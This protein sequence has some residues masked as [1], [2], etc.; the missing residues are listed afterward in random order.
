MSADVFGRRHWRT[1]DRNLRNGILFISTH[2]NPWGGCEELW[3][4]TA[5]FLARQGVAV[6]ASVQG[7]VQ[8]D[9]R[10]SALAAVGVD[11]RPRPVKPSLVT[12]GRR[13]LSGRSTMS[14]DIADS[15][16]GASPRLVVISDG[17]VL[18]PVGVVELCAK[19]KWPFATIANV[20]APALWPSDEVAQTW[21]KLL[22]SAQRCFFVSEENRTL[23]ERQLGYDFANAEVIRNPLIFDV[24]TSLAWPKPDPGEELRMACVGRL[25]IPQKGQDLLLD[26]LAKPIWRDRT[27]RLTFYGNGPNRVT[28]ERL[29]E[30]L[31]LSDR[32]VFGGHAA[33]EAIWRDNHILVVPS[34]Y[35]GV[36]MTTVEAMLCGRPV[37]ATRVGAN[38][39]IIDDGVNGFL[40]EP[41]VESIGGALERMWSSRTQL[42]GIGQRAAKSVRMFMP[43]D[44]VGVFAARL[45]TLAGL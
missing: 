24:T 1:K 2:T 14:M 22:P 23:L 44:P 35:E 7:F 45:R 38:P 20:N 31:T 17:G 8:L 41:T 43:D 40:A 18:P 26:A 5:T 4:R 36:P 3:T 33:V 10:T 39:E 30:K 27:W 11:L 6:A 15:F 16:G 25:H 32:V 42:E 12:Y 37:V 21:R 28:M 34:R 13:Y 19:N 9:P 29:V